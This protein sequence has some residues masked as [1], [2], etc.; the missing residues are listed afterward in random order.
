MVID[1]QLGI[2]GAA[3]VFWKKKGDSI[4]FREAFPNIQHATNVTLLRGPSTTAGDS[5][6]SYFIYL[7][8]DSRSITR[9]RHF[10]WYLYVPLFPLK[11][12]CNQRIDAE[13]R[14]ITSIMG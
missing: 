7:P 14:T 3:V 10:A 1:L 2:S 8:K 4:L 12:Q 9:H 6:L 11:V 13:C 5:K